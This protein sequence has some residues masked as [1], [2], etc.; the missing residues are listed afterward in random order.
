MP[1]P[2]TFLDI[3]HI[4]DA[5]LKHISFKDLYHCVLVSRAWHNALIPRLWQDVAT[6]RRVK[7]TGGKATYSN[8]FLTPQ[9]HEALSKY[10]HHIRRLTCRG[11]TLLFVLLQAGVSSLVELAYVLELDPHLEPSG[12]RTPLNLDQLLRLIAANP[13]LRSVSVKNIDDSTRVQ[14]HQSLAEFVEALNA[15]P[16]VTRLYVGGLLSSYDKGFKSPILAPLERR[17]AK[18]DLSRVARLEFK[19]PQHVEPNMGYRRRWENEAF[20]FFIGENNSL[21][22]IHHAATLQI[23]MPWFMYPVAAASTLRRF[24]AL[25]GLSMNAHWRQ[26]GQVLRE[27]SVICPQLQ[28]ISLKLGGIVVSDLARYLSCP[29]V[30]LSTVRLEEIE[31]HIYYS[32]LQPLLL[33]STPHFLRSALVQAQVACLNFPM[34]SLLEILSLCPNLR[35]LSAHSVRIDGSEPEVP[36]TWASRQLRVLNLGIS[37]KGNQFVER[38]DKEVLAVSE[39]SA[40]MIAPSFMV[41]LG[42]QKHLSDL[43]LSFGKFAKEG[44][45]PFLELSLDCPNGLKQ[46]E[47][48]SR[49]TMVKISGLQ[50]SVGDVEVAWMA[51]KWRQLRYI[52]LPKRNFERSDRIWLP[53]YKK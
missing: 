21:A 50:H 37:L 5:V 10:S 41:Q 26:G 53:Y 16:S 3:P 12:L 32:A 4:V 7:P 28:D 39:A 48:L 15:F 27:L 34:S 23:C 51:Q 46:L 33:Q 13:W 25:Q 38:I 43:E 42:Q 6:F 30:Q 35:I 8:C 24:P 20:H 2:L 1:L 40:A 44:T 14:S 9:S 18:V 22:V 29:D 49:L 45:S 47:A 17:L 36:P 11:N 19:D 31:T 52:R